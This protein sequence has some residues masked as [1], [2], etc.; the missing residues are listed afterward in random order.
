MV[1][2]QRHNSA[3]T[4]AFIW[5]S[6]WV[7]SINTH[8]T[9][10]YLSAD[11]DGWTSHQLKCWFQSKNCWSVV[12]TISYIEARC[13]LHFQTPN[14][15]YTGQTY[16]D[17]FWT[18]NVHKYFPDWSLCDAQAVI[19]ISLWYTALYFDNVVCISYVYFCNMIQEVEVY[20][21]HPP[22]FDKLK[23]VYCILSPSV[24]LHFQSRTYLNYENT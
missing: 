11:T 20:G 6:H 19:K 7:F 24:P 21:K 10:L 1:W 4:L 8:T 13:S 9:L 14:I 3:T 18:P 22:Y 15:C 16:L 5:S 2:S 23:P 12:H 17:Q